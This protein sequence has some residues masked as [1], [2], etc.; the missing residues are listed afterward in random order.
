MS[1]W[2]GVCLTKATSSELG[3]G[4]NVLRYI[5]GS[6]SGR[7]CEAASLQFLCYVL[8]SDVDQSSRQGHTELSVQKEEADD[9]MSGV[10]IDSWLVS[11]DGAV[12]F[13][14]E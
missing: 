6:N 13:R 12:S 10:K 14:D 3:E 7:V 1:I 9:V 4:E 11:G 5:S 2:C 8:A